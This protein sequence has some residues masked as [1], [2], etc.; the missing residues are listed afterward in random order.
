LYERRYPQILLLGYLL[1]LLRVLV[2]LEHQP[3]VYP[4]HRELHRPQ[5]WLSLLRDRRELDEAESSGQ[6]RI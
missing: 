6:N 3:L 1:E 5:L 2:L 4:N